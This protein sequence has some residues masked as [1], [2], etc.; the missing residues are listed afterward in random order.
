MKYPKKVVSKQKGKNDEKLSRR[1]CE[2]E[3]T[4]VEEEGRET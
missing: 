2:R 3:S 1:D 4:D